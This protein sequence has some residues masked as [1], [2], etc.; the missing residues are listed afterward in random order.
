MKNQIIVNA[1]REGGA[2]FEAPEYSQHP[3]GEFAQGIGGNTDVS[4]GVTDTSL[5]NG[6][7]KKAMRQESNIF[8]EGGDMGYLNDIDDM[9]AGGFATRNNYRDRM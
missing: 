5:T 4:G 2:S 8:G 9:N 6:Y 3:Q 1:A 7:T